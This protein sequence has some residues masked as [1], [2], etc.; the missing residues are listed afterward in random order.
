MAARPPTDLIFRRRSTRRA[1]SDEVALAY[2]CV[3]RMRSA[4]T[5]RTGLRVHEAIEASGSALWRRRRRN[6]GD[7]NEG[8]FF[9]AFD[10]PP[11]RQKA[12]RLTG[13]FRRTAGGATFKRLQ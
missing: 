7:D 8:G 5:V 10:V 2:A 6:G 12:V 11:T 4:G 9:L 1:Q 3:W 13:N